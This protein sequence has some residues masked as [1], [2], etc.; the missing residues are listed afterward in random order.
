MGVIGCAAGG[1]DRPLVFSPEKDVAFSVEQGLN[2]WY[3][4]SGVYGVTGKNGYIVSITDDIPCEVKRAN[5]T[6]VEFNILAQTEHCY[7]TENPDSLLCSC[8]GKTS[9]D[10]IY[11]RK[12]S[13]NMDTII[14][15]EIGHK[16]GFKGHIEDDP[17]SVL[18]VTSHDKNA[19]ITE[20]TLIRFCETANCRQ[21]NPESP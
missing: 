9:H 2:R 14:I 16:Y 18:Y 15:H 13:L 17:S 12:D 21:F 3:I 1:S 6:D 8:A 10:G 7:P 4:A 20:H 19:K 11:V 5:Y